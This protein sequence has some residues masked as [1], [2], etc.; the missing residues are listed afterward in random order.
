MSADDDKEFKDLLAQLQ[1]SPDPTEL[2]NG[3]PLETLN[4]LNKE[5][6]P[7]EQQLE[8]Q[9][10]KPRK[11][12][13][14]SLTHLRQDYIQRLT[15]TGMVGFLFAVSKEHEFPPEIKRW[16]PEV[17]SGD[18]PNEDDPTKAPKREPFSIDKTISKVE[19]LLDLAKSVKNEQFEL[20]NIRQQIHTER[21]VTESKSPNKSKA[22]EGLLLAEKQREERRIVLEY[23]VTHELRTMGI[24][25]DCDMDE[26]LEKAKT[27]P[28][29]KDLLEK[30][31]PRKVVWQPRNFTYEAPNHVCRAVVKDFLK[32]W[33]EYNPNEHAKSAHN[34][35]KINRDSTDDHRVDLVDPAR[36]TKTTVQQKPKVEQADVADYMKI[37]AE[38][39]SKDAIHHIMRDPEL[40]DF[41][42]RCSKDAELSDRFRRYLAFIS[43]DS[44][45]RAAIDTV[46][47]Q[48]TYHRWNYY[49]DVNYEEL[50][51]AVESL[52]DMKPDF[53]DAIFPYHTIEGTEEEIEKQR[54]DYL[55][56][57]QDS[58]RSDVLAVNFGH[59][60]LTGSFKKNRDK[61]D[62][63]NKN[64]E[65]IK[66]IMDRIESDKAIGKDLMQK[67]V[68][69]EKAK[70]IKQAGPDAAGL[71]QYRGENKEVMAL[72]AQKVLDREKMLRLEKAGG[73]VKAAQ[74]LEYL[75]QKEKR[76]NEL[77]E[78]KKTREWTPQ[79]DRENREVEREIAQ[80]RE[81]MNAPE[82]SVQ[83]DVFTHNAATGDFN[84]SAM[85]TKA[86]APTFMED[87]K[88]EQMKMLQNSGL[89]MMPG[90]HQA[91]L[92]SA[93]DMKKDDTKSVPKS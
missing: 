27:L 86:E 54:R 10:N 69:K 12:V 64:T 85:Y 78:I 72:G 11:A 63:Y 80:A 7:Y 57:N 68:V 5:L 31:P 44:P 67:R 15:L 13:L 79:E 52:Y 23:L 40:A 88:K 56:K 17:K 34:E 77:S 35:P 29:A 42:V 62:Y 32:K 14:L 9:K 50:R 45:A 75:E 55:I 60:N 93:A 91:L 38:R 37:I 53:E 43:L 47:P 84:R 89:A 65:I 51:S 36:P 48:D 76:R 90:P 87:N 19:K 83:V 81:L 82:D 26:T 1:S 58:L 22:L 71:T 59:W 20:K 6:S 49:M 3:L 30:H 33:F 16:Q 61:I 28:E 4:K 66:R 25:A 18:K 8:D 73:N 24:D 70:N 2:I 21:A 74:E 39:K 92:G 46:P 41:V